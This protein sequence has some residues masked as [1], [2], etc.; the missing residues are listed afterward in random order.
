LRNI[1]ISA[2]Q[3]DVNVLFVRKLTSFPLTNMALAET[4][5]VNVLFKLGKGD[6]NKLGEGKP[7]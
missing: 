4:N 5:E 2:A 7:Y 3:N 1:A 6:R